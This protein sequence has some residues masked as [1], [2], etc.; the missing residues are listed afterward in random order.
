[1]L[2]VVVMV[3]VLSGCTGP[4]E[5][6]HNGFKVGPNYKR[7]PAAVANEWIDGRDP[8]VRSLPPD[9]S[10]WWT[11]FNDPVLNSLV[12]AAYEQNL[13]LREAGFRVLQARAQKCIATGYFF[14]QLQ[15]ASASYTHRAISGTV[16]NRE[17]TPVRYFDLYN[18]GLSLAWEL[19]FWGRFRRAIEAADATLNATVED[20]DAVL[21]MLV[22]DVARTYVQL[23]TLEAR[24]SYLR[25]NVRLQQKSLEVALERFHGG[26]ASE[27]DPQQAAANLAETEALIPP[28][29]IQL[30][31]ACN[32]LCLLLGIP[33]DDLEKKL[34]PCPIPATCSEVVVGIPADL[35]RRRPDVRRAERTLAAQSAQIGVAVSEL[36]PHITILG[37]FG[38]QSS[39]L[40]D[41]FRPESQVGNIGP[42][43]RWNI[44][45]YG[46]LLSGIRLEN[47]R[48][49]ELVAVYQNTVLKAN[50]EVENGLVA[51]LRSQEQVQAQQKAV[52]AVQ[53]SAE[54]AL[55]QFQEGQRDINRVYVLE[56]DLTTQ[57]DRLA[58]AQGNVALGLIEVY[59]AL[60]GGWQIRLGSNQ[61]ALC[62]PAP[63][64]PDTLPKPG[65]A[66]AVPDQVPAKERKQP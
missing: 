10:H 27:L 41:L 43:I 38:V 60:G 49:Q 48:F 40:S 33:P 9:D 21:V 34:Q 8:R 23:R 63:P 19:D 46:R 52:K 57:Q 50:E 13:S 26:V 11:S 6:I 22:A 61:P 55:V 17:F 36:Y 56:R 24:L 30:R 66:M 31:Q 53:R 62:P 65:E 39:K 29:Q 5:Y 59:R 64:V 3:L 4:L 12:Q 32:Q 42:S 18:T 2:S 47:A 20:Y 28:I 35:L 25:E 14:P 1:L 16:A 58:Q 15:D 51:F 44:L 45:N 54:L 7:P 37:N